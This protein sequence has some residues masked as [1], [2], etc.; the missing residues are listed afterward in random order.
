MAPELAGTLFG[1]TNTIA[2]F[3]GFLAPAIAN[4]FTKN[5]V[6]FRVFKIAS[7]LFK[8]FFKK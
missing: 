1:I 7:N 4:A 6:R 3:P 2:S 8:K 5:E